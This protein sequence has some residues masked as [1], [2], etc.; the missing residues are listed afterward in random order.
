MEGLAEG[1][2]VQA[3]VQAVVA[4]IQFYMECHRSGIRQHADSCQVL[5]GHLILVL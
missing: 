2:S 3:M 4:L 5:F 1:V